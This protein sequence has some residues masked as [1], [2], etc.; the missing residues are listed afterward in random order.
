MI[1]CRECGKELPDTAQFCSDCGAQQGDAKAWYR[2]GKKY[3]NGDGVPQ[4][5]DMA[6]QWYEKAAEQ[7]HADAQYNLGSMY[8]NG[9]GVPYDR[10]KAK[11]WYQKAAQQGHAEARYELR[12][13]LWLRLI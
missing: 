12:H 10:S 5:Y 3:D 1:Y 7:G 11:E 6:R 2:L 4:D 8:S 9:E 13:N